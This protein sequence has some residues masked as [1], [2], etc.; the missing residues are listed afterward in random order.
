MQCVVQE[1]IFP[2]FIYVH[3]VVYLLTADC[4][5]LARHV[6]DNKMNLV[7]KAHIHVSGNL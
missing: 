2:E 3:D 7:R 5:L 1:A 4:L 6:L